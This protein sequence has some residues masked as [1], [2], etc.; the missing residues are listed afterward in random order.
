MRLV[1]CFGVVIFLLGLVSSNTAFA[2]QDAQYTHYMFNSLA[3]NPGYAGTRGALNFTALGRFQWVGVEG[4][5]KTFVLSG[6]SP[7]TNQN[8]GVGGWVETD[9][10]GVH[11]RTSLFGN[12]AYHLPVSEQNALSL[13]LT[14]GFWH[15]AS[16]WGN[17]GNILNPDDPN[18]INESS[19]IL[20]NFGLGAFF[21]GE[22]YYAGLSAPHILAQ[23]LDEIA[24]EAKQFLHLYLTGGY[25]FPLSEKLQLMPTALVKMTPNSSPVTFDVN[26]NLIFDNKFGIGVGYRNSDAIDVM[27]QFN[28]K[29]LRIGYAYDL[30]LS[31]L[32]TFGSG[33]HEIMLGID[34]GNKGNDDFGSDGKVLSPRFF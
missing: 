4:A 12:Y 23:K 7:I 10:I 17:A 14:A 27:L 30:T 24:L 29:Q 31:Q 18:A 28:H 20:P 8:M 1:L 11:N 33:S 22:N 34:L 2:Q 19:K 25:L 9:R 6:H 21:Y 5:P 13:G 15:Y 32:K 3:F 26:A 16:N